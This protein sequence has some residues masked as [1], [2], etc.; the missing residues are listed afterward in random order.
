MRGMMGWMAGGLVMLVLGLWLSTHLNTSMVSERNLRLHEKLDQMEKE[1]GIFDPS[2]RRLPPVKRVQM[3]AM[4]AQEQSDI[5][6]DDMKRLIAEAE[7][8]AMGAD[9]EE[10]EE[11][12]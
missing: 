6:S 8:R 5:L 1:M 4:F 9:V 7:G 10:S 2:H 11:E 3:V 12:E